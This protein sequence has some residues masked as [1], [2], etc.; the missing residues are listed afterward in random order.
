MRI[1]D[2]GFAKRCNNGICSPSFSYFYS[3]PECFSNNESHTSQDVWSL[4]VILYTMLMGCTPFI[5]KA[6]AQ[7][8]IIDKNSVLWNL[9]S[10]EAKD[11]I[12]NLIQV[13]EQKRLTTSQIFKH[14]W[15]CD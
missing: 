13:D 4:G 12:I 10:D 8:G 11:L 7:L 15:M 6:D 9:L 2:F 14:S 3:P 1:V 5:T